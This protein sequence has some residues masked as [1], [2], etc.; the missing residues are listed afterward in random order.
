MKV[1]RINH[2]MI[3]PHLIIFTKKPMAAIDVRLTTERCEINDKDCTN[4]YPYNYGK[5]NQKLDVYGKKKIIVTNY[6]VN[7][8]YSR[9]E[10]SFT[11]HRGKTTDILYD[12]TIDIPDFCRSLIFVLDEFDY[13]EEIMRKQIVRSDNERVATFTFELVE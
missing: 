10:I 8:P 4:V 2:L 12:C 11:D 3:K 13:S 1:A 5:D 9:V 6:E 7:K